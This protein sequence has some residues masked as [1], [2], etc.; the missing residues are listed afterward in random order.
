[1]K[2]KQSQSIVGGEGE[3]AVMK[4]IQGRS[5]FFKLWKYDNTSMGDLENI[6]Q[7]YI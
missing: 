5:L 3:Y 7:S 2:K 6:E 4:N 1:M